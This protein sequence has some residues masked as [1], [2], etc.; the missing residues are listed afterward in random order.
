MT[1]PRAWL[2]EMLVAAGRQLVVAKRSSRVVILCYHSVSTASF[3]SATP[4][5]FEQHLR[6]LRTHCEIVPF[7]R[8]AETAGGPPGDRPA[9]AITFDDGYADNYEYAFP[10]L[11]S[12][13]VP[14]TFF[15]TAGLL[16]RHPRVVER[17]QTLYHARDIRPLEWAQVREMRSAGMEFGAHTYSHPNLRR[18]TRSAAE[19]ELRQSKAILEDHLSERVGAMAYPFGIPRRHFTPE[20]M[21]LAA[22]AGYD[23]A[24]AITL[25]ALQRSHSRLA[26]PRFPVS[27]GGLG[28]LTDMIAGAWDL[29]GVWQE[30]APLALQHSRWDRYE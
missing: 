25:R 5:E 9:V 11:Q 17:F 3:A 20:T 21:D 14:A 1:G 23:C 29:F 16:E 7:R 10:L 22:A 15:L 6:W 18:L 12:Y 24:A 26:I 8:A 27:R 30:R 13:E 2:K 19:T 28:T 4:Q